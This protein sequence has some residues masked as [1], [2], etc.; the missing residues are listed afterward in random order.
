MIVTFRQFAFNNVLRNKRLYIAYFLSSLFTVMVFFTFANFAFHPELSGPDMRS[1]VLQGLSVAGGI[2]YVFSFFFILYSMSS[3]LQS[4]KKEF[5]ILMIHGTSHR[6]I[7]LMV[8]LENM[9]IGFFATIIGIGLGLVFSKV[10]LLIAENVLVLD[11]GL[12]FY[13]PLMAI[14]ITFVSFIVLFL[15]ISFFVTFILR[16]NKLVTLIKGDKI[17]K[18]EPKFSII[19]VILAI[20]LL[21]I[22][23]VIA[24]RVTGVA[25]AI[26]LLPVA[27]LVTIGTYLLF[28]QLS[29]FIIRKLKNNEKLFWR[30][31]NML[32]F[33]DLS[34]R[35][36]DNARTFFMVAIISTVAFSAI[37]TLF[38]MKS[39]LTKGVLEANPM[40][41]SLSIDEDMSDE[42]VSDIV[43]HIEATLKEKNI[44]TKDVVASLHYFKQQ[45]DEPAVLITTDTVYNK[46]AEVLGEKEVSVSEDEVI[47][48]DSS[49]RMITMPNTEFELS[50]L[51]LDDG[52]TVNVDYSKKGIA[53]RDIIPAMVEYYIVSETLFEQLGEPAYSNNYY[54]W[55]VV[56]GNQGDIIE[57][58]GILSEEYETTFF[59]IDH[60]VYI[61][62]KVYSPIMF[63]GLFIGIIFFVSS[64]S[65]LYFRLYTDLDEDKEKFTAINKIGLTEKEMTKVITR[66]TAIL[67]FTPIIVAILHGAVALTALSN[68]FDYNLVKESVIVLSGFFVIQVIYF[69]FVRY[70]YVKQIKEAV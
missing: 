61:I 7:R 12:T 43:T 36:K 20:L 1:D 38:G 53:K 42:E 54:E 5:G 32:L 16:T 39:F 50:S 59:A 18:S 44:E 14:L 9:L 19:L 65:F 25:V 34:Y 22:G 57:A 27:L 10:I 63:V 70:F 6:Q 51:T 46:Y 45:E 11:D 4:R 52:S 26:A 58:G 64:G 30:K 69:L 56:K 8:F 49:I 29:V 55:Q 33:S 48:V 15:F 41:Y 17:G 31:T 24:L 23:Y 47:P 67:F 60:V 40:S 21:G 37:G 68:M 35:M 28:T 62:E 66:Q 2:I 13:F 3:F